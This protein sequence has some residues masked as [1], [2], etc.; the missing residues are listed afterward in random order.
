LFVLLAA[1]TPSRAQEF[2]GPDGFA[3]C[4][5]TATQFGPCEP[6]TVSA[7]QSYRLS[8]EEV[9]I[10]DI[11]KRYAATSD[12]SLVKELAKSF[13]APQLPLATAKIAD[14]WLP[15][16]QHDKSPSNCFACGIHLRY[17]NDDLM[18]MT[19]T[20]ASRFSVIW[21]RVMVSAPLK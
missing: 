6:L 17:T 2:S 16:R 19:Y 8:A 21:N 13:A 9:R 4:P 1:A 14:F 18:Q 12:H 7:Q 3:I 10:V 15:D 11:L 5:F 20:V